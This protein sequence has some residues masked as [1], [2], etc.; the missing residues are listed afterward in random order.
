[1]R[2]GLAYLDAAEKCRH[3]ARQVRDPQKK[4]QLEDMALEEWEELATERVRQLAN[5]NGRDGPMSAT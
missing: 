1:M 3:L 5:S 4:K 2:E